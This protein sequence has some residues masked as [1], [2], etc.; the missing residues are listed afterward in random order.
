M[1]HRPQ[2]DANICID[3]KTR[4]EQ[5]LDSDTF[6][7]AE[8]ALLERPRRTVTTA[9]PVRMD[10]GSIQ[11]FNAYRVLYSNARGPGKG[12]VR[13][14]HQVDL[15]EV[16]S[17]AFL[18][19]LKC[20]LLDVPFGGAK[21][22]IEVD[23]EDISVAEKERLAR[24]Y[25][26]EFQTVLGERMDIPA[27]DMN[28]DAETMAW[29]ADEYATLQGRASFGVVTG[30][31]V[32]LG[33][34]AGRTEATARGGASALHT[35]FH[36]REDTL[37]GKT[38]AIQ[39]FGNVGAHIASLLEEWGARVVAIADSKR[40]VYNPEGLSIAA[41]RAT[42]D[43]GNLPDDIAAETIDNKSLLRLP[44][45]VLV[46]AAVSHQVTATNAAE[47]NASVILEMAND[48]ITPDADDI[49]QQK[50][51][52]ILPDIL[53]NAG[54][55][56]VSYFEWVQNSSNFYWP[57]ARVEKELT[58]RMQE[59]VRAVLNA[60]ENRFTELRPY[61]FRLAARRII[62]AEELRGRL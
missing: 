15:T 29:M 38:V 36:E 39:G 40:A 44:V 25:I 20:A 37:H 3:C 30:K 55:V 62:D 52:V 34:S 9:I 5:I 26:R 19:A 17:L 43:H 58:R 45:D 46:P 24:G 21:G 50:G 10:D 56:L 48:P 49:L 16:R 28:T 54:G 11:N 8:R 31:P 33:G 6:T 35:Y 12:G 22:G 7:A 27:P 59:A 60:S 41:I 14:H 47:I 23:M 51:I 4:L 61:A 13:F 42:H 1:I 53:A 2:E 57:L 18:M 32:S